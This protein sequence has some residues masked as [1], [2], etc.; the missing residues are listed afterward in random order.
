M[1]EYTYKDGT[2]MLSECRHINHCW[3]SVSEHAHGDQGVLRHRAVAWFQ[4]ADGSK[5]RS[6]AKGKDPY[7]QEHDDLFPCDPE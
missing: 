4:M 5:W 7:Q 6:E 2:K 3:N 1:I